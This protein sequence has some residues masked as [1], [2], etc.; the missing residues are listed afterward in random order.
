VPLLIHEAD[1]PV[2]ARAELRAAL[3]ADPDRRTSRL[4]A[5]AA[6]IARAIDLAPAEARMLVGLSPAECSN[7]TIS[8]S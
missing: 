7:V 2:P 1:V 6:L 8:N 3:Y 5:A 4:E